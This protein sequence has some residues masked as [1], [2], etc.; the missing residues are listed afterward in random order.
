MTT[1]RPAQKNPVKK[2]TTKSKKPTDKAAHGD[3]QAEAIRLRVADTIGGLMDFWGFKRP[4]GRIWTLLYI[5]PEP[6]SAAEIAQ[7]MHMSA[8]SVSMTLGELLGWGAIRRS[9]RPGTRREY[10]AAETSVWK[11]VSRVI[12]ERELRLVTEARDTFAEADAVLLAEEKGAA[13]KER[14]AQLAFERARVG[15][16]RV[17]AQTG[18]TLLHSL[19]AGQSIEPSQLDQPVGDGEQEN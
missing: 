5:S 4:M 13:D 1:K 6:L 9:W 19:V 11:L 17:L 12:R 8:G 2:A 15:Q 10:F 18:E 16:L 14:A 7:R 3:A